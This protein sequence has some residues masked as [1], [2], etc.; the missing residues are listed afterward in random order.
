M[1]RNGLRVLATQ[2]RLCPE[3]YGPNQNCRATVL[4]NQNTILTAE[5]CECAAVCVCVRKGQGERV[6][7]R[8]FTYLIAVGTFCCASA[9]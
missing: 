6:Y 8:V 9:C 2:A 7:V 3:P 4:C 5:N 1:C